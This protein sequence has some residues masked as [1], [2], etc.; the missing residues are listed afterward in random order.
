[1]DQTIGAYDYI[2]VGGGLSGLL[3]AYRMSQHPVLRQCAVLMLESEE[4]NNN[5]RTWCYWEEGKGEWDHLLTQSWSKARVQSLDE[6]CAIPLESYA[7]KMLRSEQWYASIHAELATWTT[8]ERRREKVIQCVEESFGATV[9][10]DQAQYRAGHVLSSVMGL[11]RPPLPNSDRMLHQ[12]FGGWFIRTEQAVFQPDEVVLMDFS[13]QQ[14]DGVCFMYVLPMTTTTALV[15][16]TVFGP[17]PWQMPRYAQY[18]KDYIGQWN[19]PYTIEEEEMG[20]IPMTVYPFERNNGN[21][22]T[23][24]G[25]AGG[26]TRPSTGYTFY[27]SCSY[28]TQLV[29]ALAHRRRIPRYLSPRHRF[30]DAVMLELIGAQPHWGADFFMRIYRLHPIDRVFRFL[31]GRSAWWEEA[32]IILKARPRAILL[33]NV[34][35][36]LWSKR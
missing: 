14:V 7:Y 6:S 13:V 8:F 32:L 34:W 25:S 29:D 28:A 20:S 5:D 2:I 17:Q 22:I 10:T 9:I 33:R 3:T 15:E 27:N 12:H 1:M 11:H 24:I 26:W 35:Q 16:F 23:Y 19:T 18:M 31:D 4:K 30:F 36:R 21:A